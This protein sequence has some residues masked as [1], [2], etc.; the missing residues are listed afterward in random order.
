MR[1]I[2]QKI[3]CTR[4]GS[5]ISCPLRAGTSTC[6]RCDSADL[7]TP[8][9]R[10]KKKSI[11]REL[12][13]MERDLDEEKI[14]VALD[15]A[16]PNAQALASIARQVA[17]DIDLLHGSSI[18]TPLMSRFISLLRR[19]GARNIQMP[20]CDTCWEVARLTHCFGD[21]RVCARCYSEFRKVDNC[22]GCGKLQLIRRMTEWG[23]P[24]CRR[25]D[26]DVWDWLPTS[27]LNKD[28]PA[29]RTR[30]ARSA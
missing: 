3:N 13:W 12:A 27:R 20:R 16:A 10:A 1:S 30:E 25:C 5:H 15:L 7:T 11:L 6:A 17:T 22:A 2:E 9:A 28:R 24:L 14:L 8:E 4:C 19:A 23:E 21:K 29:A 26:S 18:A